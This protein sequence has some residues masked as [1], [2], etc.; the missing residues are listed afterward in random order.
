MKILWIWEIVIDETSTTNDKIKEWI[1]VQLNSKTESTKSIWWPVPAWLKLLSN[2]WYQT[3]IIWSIWDDLYWKY[4]ENKIKEYKIENKLIIDKATKVNRVI[5]N[6]SNWKRTIL[7][8]ADENEKLKKIPLELIKEADVVIFDRHEPEAFDFVIK[9]KRKDTKIIMDPSTE[10]SEKIINMTRCLDYPIFP[11]EAL[12]DSMLSKNEKLLEIYNISKKPTIITDW[13]KWSYIFNWKI[14]RII[15]PIE[16][17]PVDKDGAW[18]VFRAWFIHWVLQWWTM[19]SAVRFANIVAGLQCLR[20]WNLTAI[21]SRGEI[22]DYIE[23][24]E[25]KLE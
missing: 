19:E 25:V 5:V 12:E 1:K 22:E 15:K 13:K 23:K 11:V 14:T 7:R 16:I 24:Y 9:N 10:F 3:T 20:K 6:T 8:W 21:P 2:L 17:K 18:D 4:I